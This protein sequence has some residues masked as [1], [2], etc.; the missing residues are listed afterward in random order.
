LGESDPAA[1]AV[2]R[3]AALLY[4]AAL[5]T[6][7]SDEPPAEPLQPEPIVSGFRKLETTFPP[8]RT[9]NEVEEFFGLV[10]THDPLVLDRLPAERV[11]ERM[12]SIRALV[13][14]LGELV[15]PRT[16]RA[17]HVQRAVR[18]SILGAVVAT[19]LVWG[20][21]RALEPENI[22]LSKPVSA[23]SVHPAAISQPVGLVDGVTSGSYGVHT[24]REDSPWVQVD[25]LDVFQI[26]E[27]RIY[28]RGDGWFDAGL[29]MS[30]QLSIDGKE[31][32]E[33]DKRTQSFGQDSPW[34]FRG[35][36]RKAR[37]VR[38]AAAPGTY[39]SLSE[40]EVNGEK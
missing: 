10:L 29:P 3:E 12:L 27:I 32:V 9:A 26:D 16:L 14:W 19:L 11:A 35:E 40:L 1:L 34:T 23:S 36:Q 2:Y 15:E 22:A 25:L 37:Y 6:V 38:V 18:V 31:F 7:A 28:N 39:V 33:A 13:A 24:D 21:V 20:I 8:S 17:I 4:M 5:L 30:L